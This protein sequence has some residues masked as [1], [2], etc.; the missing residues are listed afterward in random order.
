MSALDK[1][2]EKSTESALCPK[3]SHGKL[4]QCQEPLHLFQHSS[5]WYLSSRTYRIRFY[6]SRLTPFNS[7]LKKRWEGP[8]YKGETWLN[9][10]EFQR[11]NK[12]LNHSMTQASILGKIGLQ[13]FQ[14]GCE[15][16]NYVWCQLALVFSDS[17]LQVLCVTVR[18]GDI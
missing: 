17:T 8:T 14:K 6:A 3:G 18:S 1:K 7:R 4:K 12:L 16:I 15:S 2:P 9:Q 10:C 11:T 13:N 5:T